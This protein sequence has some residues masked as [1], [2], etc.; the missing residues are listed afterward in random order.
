MDLLDRLLGHDVW[1][2]RQLLLQSKSLPDAKLDQ[3]FDIDNRTLRECFVHII[4]NM[5]VWADLLHERPVTT[6]RAG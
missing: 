1:S 3:R 6:G 5:E 4:E 2:T